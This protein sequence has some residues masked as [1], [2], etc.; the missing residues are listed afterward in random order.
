MPVRN[1]LV[2]SPSVALE[3]YKGSC[4]NETQIVALGLNYGHLKGDSQLWDPADLDTTF[5]SLKRVH[6]NPKSNER[7]GHIKKSASVLLF[8]SIRD[9]LQKN[10]F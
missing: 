6:L 7:V 4:F 3:L 5:V 8:H 10:S 9:I 2:F 1:F